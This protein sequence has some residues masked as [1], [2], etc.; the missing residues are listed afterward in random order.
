MRECTDAMVVVVRFFSYFV[1]IF[2]GVFFFSTQAVAYGGLTMVSDVISDSVPAGTQISHTILFTA[3]LP[4]PVGGKII[5]RPEAIQGNFT[6]PVALDFTDIDFAVAPTSTMPFVERALAAVPSATEDGVVVVPGASGTITITLGSGATAPILVGEVVRIKIGSVAVVGSI[7]DQYIVSPAILGSHNIRLETRNAADVLIQF[8]STV[9]VMV[10]PVTLGRADTLDNVPP[11]RTNGLPSP[12]LLPGS[13]Q[14]VFL[15]LNTDKIALCRY[16]TTSGTD[17]FSMLPSTVFSTANNGL[18]HFQSIPVATST[19]YN[20]YVRCQKF[21]NT[22]NPDDYLI[23]FEIGIEPTVITPPAPPPPPPS[24]GGSTGFG[25]GGGVGG[26]FLGLG[27]VTMEGLAAPGSTLVILKDGVIER[28]VVVPIL[29]QFSEKFLDLARGTYAW[30][31]YIRD[32]QRRVSSTYT[33]TI[34]LIGRTNNVIAPVHVSPT[35]S[36]SSTTVPVGG[37][38]MLSG[39]AIALTPVQVLMNKQG[40]AVTGNIISATTTANGNGSW[41]LELPSDGLTKGTYEI[42]A[43]SIFTNNRDRSLISPIIYLGL[44]IDPSPSLGNRSDLNRD[45]KVNLV[46]FSILLFNWRGTD[47]VSDINQDGTV[48][49]TDFSIMLSNW[50]G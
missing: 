18:L 4:I 38:V 44:G 11:L 10:A 36:V 39:Y 33:S 34:Y 40:N 12:G 21:T 9:V 8:G 31:A 19:T 28:E 6:I 22:P 20:I 26:P 3:N 43:V 37:K 17:F 46:D 2:G 7:G 42:K 32:P 13:T 15:S 50:T 1:F 5:F 48:N 41:T 29:G 47:P 49:L 24:S 16:A 30:G 27:E 45:G 14:N 35:I 25:G 23:T